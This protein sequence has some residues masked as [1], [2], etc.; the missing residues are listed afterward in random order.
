MFCRLL[1]NAV[2]QLTNTTGED[3]VAHTA[4]DIG[5]YGLLPRPYIPSDQRRLEAYR[6]LASAATLEELDAVERDLVSAYGDLPPPA[7]RLALLARLRAAAQQ[8]GVRAVAAR[9]GDVVLMTADPARVAAAL[10]AASIGPVRTV[11][12]DLAQTNARSSTGRPLAEIYLRP[13]AKLASDPIGLAKAL[14]RALQPRSAAD[15]PA[16]TAQAADPC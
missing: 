13:P 5:V 15:P 2:N 3:P 12:A 7:K 14:I 10:E 1:D 9:A 4:V 8:W 6:R 11:A 16:A